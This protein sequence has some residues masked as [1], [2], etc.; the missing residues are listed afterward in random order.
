[1][2]TDSSYCIFRTETGELRGRVPIHQDPQGISVD[3]S[4]LYIAIAARN[5]SIENMP[6]SRWAMGNEFAKGTRTRILFYELGTGLLAGEISC[7]FDVCSFSFSPNGQYF[8]AG[9]MG[10]S[11]SIWSLSQ[12]M[13]GNISRV[14][15]QMDLKPDF[16]SAY[17]IFIKNDFIEEREQAVPHIELEPDSISEP[18]YA[19][20]QL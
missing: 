6:R 13:I 4:G 5:S 3:P 14:L 18:N 9:S 11:V 17:P 19:H 16:W 1:M 15:N 2:V 7:L 10:G 12:D 8:V 20:L